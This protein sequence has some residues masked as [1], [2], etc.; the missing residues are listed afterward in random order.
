M[1]NVS[2]VTPGS[3]VG[4]RF[5]QESKRMQL[6]LVA[7]TDQGI[8]RIWAPNQAKVSSMAPHAHPNELK[9]VFSKL[10]PLGKEIAWLVC[11][12]SVIDVTRSGFITGFNP[13]SKSDCDLQPVINNSQFF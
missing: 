8:H 12:G 2:M 10:F 3:Q 13:D 4:T 6:L 9:R 5:G 7:R 11:C 1:Q